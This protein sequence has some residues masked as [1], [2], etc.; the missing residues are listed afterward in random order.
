MTRQF[1]RLAV[2]VASAALITTATVGLNAAP[3]S[4]GYSSCW[5]VAVAGAKT[6]SGA[7]YDVT[8]PTKW[9]LRV[10]CTWGQSRTSGWFGGSGRVDVTCPSGTVVR[11]GWIE[12]D[13][14]GNGQ[15]G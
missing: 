12:I 9:R 8:S 5:R 10:S 2:G 13:S 6:A 11:D 4:A 7:C 14:D 3:A 15:P 1:R